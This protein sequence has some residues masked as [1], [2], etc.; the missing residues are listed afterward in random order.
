MKLLLQPSRPDSS[1][2]E[3]DHQVQAAIT[4]LRGYLIRIRGAGRFDDGTVGILPTHES[5]IEIAVAALK[6]I[7]IW[8]AIS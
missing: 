5:D 6:Q 8:G 3:V 2:F 1:T 7:G 4:A